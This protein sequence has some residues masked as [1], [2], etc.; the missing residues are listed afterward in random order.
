MLAIEIDC[1]LGQGQRVPTL[2]EGQLGSTAGVPLL[3]GVALR[4][5]PSSLSAS[6]F[7]SNNH[8]EKEKANLCPLK[9]RVV[10]VACYFHGQLGIQPKQALGSEKLSPDTCSGPG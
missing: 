8:K 1:S 10:V 6:L 5:G 2:G 4:Q 7:P 3:I 9:T